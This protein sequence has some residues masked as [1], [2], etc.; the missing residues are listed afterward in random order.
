MIAAGLPQAI[1]RVVPRG[2]ARTVKQMVAQWMYLS[3]RGLLPLQRAERYL[4]VAVDPAG[5]KELARSWA[6]ET[7][8]SDERRGPESEWPALTTHIV[9]SFP[10]ATPV[11]DAFTVAR[12]WADEMF[13]SGRHGGS[14]DYVTA[15]HSDRPHPHVH[16]VVN[17]RALEGHWLKISRRHPE[18]NYDALRD[19]L[20]EVAARHG[21]RLEA[22]SRIARASRAAA[23]MGQ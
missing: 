3:R 13:G 11:A 8:R 10:P 17:R 23:S 21:M 15:L 22:T 20:V 12:A 16:L 5:L 19:G 9:V 7:G 2:G 18:L 14:F 1:I 4:G 6:L